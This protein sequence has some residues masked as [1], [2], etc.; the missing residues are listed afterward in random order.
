M[1]RPCLII[2]LA[3]ACNGHAQVNDNISGVAAY[4]ID[5]KLVEK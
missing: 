1:K 3:V 4:L 5:E 2:L